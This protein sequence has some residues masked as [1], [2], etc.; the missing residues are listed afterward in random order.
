MH[1]VL[2]L[3]G[4]YGYRV[5]ERRGNFKVGVA[6]YSMAEE[7]IIVDIEQQRVFYGFVREVVVSIDTYWIQ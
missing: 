2:L 5:K 6:N 7:P 4:Y 1:H 3:L